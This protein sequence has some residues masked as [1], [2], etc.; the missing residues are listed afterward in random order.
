MIKILLFPFLVSF[1]LLLVGNLCQKYIFKL[2]KLHI[3]FEYIIALFVLSNVSFLI[4]FFFSLNKT[5][6]T[7][8]FLL[9][10]LSIFYLN[11]DKLKKYLKFSL[12]FLIFVILLIGFDNINRPD[13]GLYHYPFISIINENKIIIGSANLHFRFGHTSI[14]QYLSAV[15]NNHILNELGMLI[16]VCAFLFS[17]T[18]FF[19]DEINKNKNNYLLFFSFLFFF[20][21]LY[22]MNRYSYF[23]NDVPGHLILLFLSYY[24]IKYKLSNLNNFVFISSLSLFA[25][26]IKSTL[27][28]IFLLPLFYL[29][30]FK[31]KFFLFSIKNFILF[32]CFSLWLLKNVLISGCILFPMKVS[33]INKIYWNSSLAPSVH[34]VNKVSL[35]NEAWAKGWPDREDVKKSYKEYIDTGWKKTWLKIHGKLLFKKLAPLILLIFL[36]IIFISRKKNY[37]L[38][39]KRIIKI[40][41]KILLYIF[42]IGSIIWFAKFPAY[43]Y[44]SSFIIGLVILSPFVLV[45]R[46]Y[47]SNKLSK[48]FKYTAIIL[49]ATIGIKYLTKF[50]LQNKF[51]PNIY[52]YDPKIEKPQNHKKVLI[53]EKLFYFK[54]E[55]DLCMYSPSPCTNL[56]V[57][58][59]LNLIE[60]SGYKIYFL[61]LK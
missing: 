7:V 2:Q 55:K 47:I 23:G 27:I 10:F 35:E 4:N 15:F 14:L 48:I 53:N 30:F 56:Q 50:N 36:I 16:P 17:I 9:P 26:Q 20:Q 46:Y 38:K 61:D 25:F 59:K 60:K 51:W 6:N 21:I 31:R 49:I 12:L 19:Y 54:A 39:K 24:F 32:F 1:Y 33:C 41:E 37:M 13:A 57:H 29:I 52:S 22:D 44:G 8:I 40:K 18:L 43:R 28:I 34:D 5:L 3:S 58:E 45:E 11:K 42:L